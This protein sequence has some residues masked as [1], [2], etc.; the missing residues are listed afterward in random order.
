[1]RRRTLLTV[2]AV[3]LTLGLLALAPGFGPVRDA[4]LRRATGLL[5]ANGVEVT[6]DA[7]SGNAWRGV[8]L[9]GVTIRGR[10]ADIRAE[11]LEVGYFLP[12]LLGGELPLDVALDEADG[13]LDLA[14]LL[15]EGDTPGGSAP[16]LR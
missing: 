14:G 7:S 9:E 3:T 6:Y 4:L 12:S 15:P 2:A 1:M 10:G 16:S 13:T 8:A 5:A 11:R